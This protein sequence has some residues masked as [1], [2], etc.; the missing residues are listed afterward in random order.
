MFDNENGC[1]PYDYRIP[2]E[3]TRKRKWPPI[4]PEMHEKIRALYQK[5]ELNKGEILIFA[6]R[7]GYPR[8]KI[9]RYAQRHG[10][11]CKTVKEPKWT[12]EELQTLE[13]NAHHSPEIIQR[14]LRQKGFNRTIQG[15]VLKRKRMHLLAGL[16]G[17][18]ARQVAVGLGVDMHFVTTAIKKGEIKASVRALN[19]TPQQGGNPYYIRE[20]D[21]KE[22]IVDHI[23]KIDIRKVDKYWL[24]SILADKDVG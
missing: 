18:S 16:D 22:F 8:W 15:I 5:Y 2:P 20:K 7:H 10:F 12:P 21:I 1:T 19:R 13:R 17:Y 23:H 9:T 3:L 6:K 4:T 11:I 24:V 14:R